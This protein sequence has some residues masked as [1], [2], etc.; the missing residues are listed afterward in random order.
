[1][2]DLVG[3][4]YGERAIQAPFSFIVS[5]RTSLENVHRSMVGG[6]ILSEMVST[7]HW[8]RWKGDVILIPKEIC[9]LK[10]PQF[11]GTI[12]RLMINYLSIDEC[13]KKIWVRA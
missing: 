7:N 8:Y 3:E 1:M 10:P 6:V 4:M 13:W 11:L 12:D 2:S 9:R 5:R